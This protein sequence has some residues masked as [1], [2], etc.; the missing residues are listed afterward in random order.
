[1]LRTSRSPPRRTRP[2]GPAKAARREWNLAA[3]RDQARPRRKH[4]LVRGLPRQN[5]QPPLGPETRP[6]MSRSVE[7]ACGGDMASP[8]ISDHLMWSRLKDPT[9]TLDFVYV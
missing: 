7:I 8:G 6:R 5:P 4:Q 9:L 3:N 2:T 1:M